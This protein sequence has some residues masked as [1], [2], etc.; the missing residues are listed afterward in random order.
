MHAG[1]VVEGMASEKNRETTGNSFTLS[2][3][4]GAW[5]IFGTSVNQIN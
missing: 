5:L 1:R 3:V 4:Q 2:S